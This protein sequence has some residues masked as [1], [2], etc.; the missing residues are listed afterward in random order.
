MVDAQNVLNTTWKGMIDSV[1]DELIKK[2]QDTS[3]QVKAIAT[4]TIDGINSELAKGMTGQKMKFAHIF[5]QSAQSMAKSSLEKVE[6]FGLK[7]LGLGGGER[8]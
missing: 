8:A 3:S 4:Q 1:F 7:A 6:G 5:Q 2:S